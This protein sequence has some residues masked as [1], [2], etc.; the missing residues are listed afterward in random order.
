MNA[1][2]EGL[3]AAGVSEGRYQLAHDVLP[4]RLHS[5]NVARMY[6]HDKRENGRLFLRTEKPSHVFDHETREATSIDGM[7]YLADNLTLFLVGPRYPTLEELKA[8]NPN[9][10]ISGLNK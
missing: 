4:K 9:I 7:V 10:D 2:Q 8:V 5:T 3:E 1:K 6:V